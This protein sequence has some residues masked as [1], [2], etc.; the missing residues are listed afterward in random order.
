MTHPTPPP[1]EAWALVPAAPS[2]AD[3][4]QRALEVLARTPHSP[5]VA[6]AL[7]RI[8]SALMPVPIP[9]EPEVLAEARAALAMHDSATHIAL[10]RAHLALAELARLWLDTVG[11]DGSGAERPD[12][13]RWRALAVWCAGVIGPVEFPRLRER[14][15]PVPDGVE[16]VARWIDTLHDLVRAALARQRTTP[17]PS[18]LVDGIAAARRIGRATQGDLVL[19]DNETTKR[20]RNVRARA[21]VERREADLA[22]RRRRAPGEEDTFGA[23]DPEDL[24]MWRLVPPQGHQL[25][26]AMPDGGSYALLEGRGVRGVLSGPLV[27]AYLACW[28]LTDLTTEAG[29]DG[30]FDLD[31]RRVLLDLYGL[32][33]ATTTVKGKVYQRMPETAKTEF[34]RHIATLQKIQVSGAGEYKAT[35]EPLLLKVQRTADS[36]TLY[37]HSTLVRQT[38]NQAYVQVPN[39]VLRLGPDDTPLALGV[40]RALLTHAGVILRGAGHARLTLE[41]VAHVTRHPI[42]EAARRAGA[43]RAWGDLAAQL[44]R[45]VREGALGQ[46]HVEG[47]GP[48]ASVTLVPS[49]SLAAVYSLWAGRGALPKAVSVDAAAKALPRKRGRP[50][51]RAGSTHK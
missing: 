39:E 15:A 22:R 49:P 2:L 31:A 11:T 13:A 48:A 12:L 30:W 35:D 32:T 24:S 37:R 21:E 27:R 5:E 8:S 38:M 17:V 19:A 40:A 33:P 23:H 3:D 6:S 34:D 18:A 25:V 4:I 45:V 29:R 47:E 1:P 28:A 26:L 51:G 44:G 7:D 42:D 10:V 46:A 16:A 41:E 14:V 43:T 9:A 20:A 36:R 50:R